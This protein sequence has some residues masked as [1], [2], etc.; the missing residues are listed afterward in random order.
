L[1]KAAREWRGQDTRH[2]W[3]RQMPPRLRLPKGQ[4]RPPFPLSRE[5]ERRL[6]SKLPKHLAEMCLFKVNT[7]LREAEVCGLRW[8]WERK[9]D[10]ARDCQDFCV[11]RAG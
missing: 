9:I 10:G 3:L 8:E 6:F 2:P 5:E 1:N 4:T 11:T 7:G